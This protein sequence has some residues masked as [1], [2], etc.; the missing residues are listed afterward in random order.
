MIAL[1]DSVR[2]MGHIGNVFTAYNS[3]EQQPHKH[4]EGVAAF[5]DMFTSTWRGCFSSSSHFA[6]FGVD[7][8]TSRTVHHGV[9]TCVSGMSHFP[10]LT[11]V[12]PIVTHC[13]SDN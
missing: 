4:I 1:G 8:K 9:A 10:S 2:K 5:R 7:P 12:A 3:Y 6:F 13:Q 11:N